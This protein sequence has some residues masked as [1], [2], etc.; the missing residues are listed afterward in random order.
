MRRITVRSPAKDIRTQESAI[1][2]DAGAAVSLPTNFD[3]VFDGLNAFD[4]TQGLLGHLFFKIAGDL[5]ANEH[6][7]LRRLK[8]HASRLDMGMV[9]Y[10][11]MD[12]MD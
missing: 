5:A 6:V 1:G 9:V 11:E 8:A 2:N 12:S 10:R 4:G 3:F 7:A